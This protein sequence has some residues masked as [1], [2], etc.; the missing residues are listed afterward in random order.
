MATKTAKAEV[1]DDFAKTFDGLRA[2]LQPYAPKLKVVHDN[3]TY[4]YLETKQPKFR[5][6]PICFGAVRRGK[7]YVSFYLMSVY[8]ASCAPL[9][10]GSKE[11]EVMSRGAKSAAAMP[12]DLKKRMQGKSC[13][14]FKQPDALLFKELAELTKRGFDGYRQLGWL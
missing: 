6:K 8:A 9:P 10:K 7:N 1:K 13:F 3:G 4:Y 14:N 2:I 12:P 11:A 5:G